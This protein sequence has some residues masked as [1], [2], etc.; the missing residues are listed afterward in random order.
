MS[1]LQ[2]YGL[3]LF[4]VGLG[5][6]L[7]VIWSWSSLRTWT[8][9]GQLVSGL[10][11]TSTALVLYANPWLESKMGVRTEAQESLKTIILN[12]YALLVVPVFILCLLWSREEI[13]AHRKKQESNHEV[14]DN[15]DRAAD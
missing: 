14:V 12:T 2:H 15:L 1:R 10:F 5:Y 13:R 3:A 11:L 8:R 6:I 4:L 9:L 7:Q